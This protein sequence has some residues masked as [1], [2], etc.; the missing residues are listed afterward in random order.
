MPADVEFTHPEWL[1]ALPLV[2]LLLVFAR[3]PW[4]RA[5]AARR[6]MSPSPLRGEIRRLALRLAWLALPLLALA[7]LS[8]TRSQD[9][10]AVVFVVD[11]SASVAPVR[12][13]QLEAVNEALSS[14]R[15]EDIAG[16]VSVG[17]GAR[18]E[19]PLTEGAILDL[20][21]GAPAEAS[22]LASGLILAGGLIP[23]DRTGRV[24]LVSDGR[25]TSG[26][27]EAAARDLSGRGIRVDVI[28]VGPEAVL[29]VRLDQIELP[30]TARERESSVMRLMATAGQPV[31]AQMRVFRDDALI[32]EQPLQ[33]QT[34]RQELALALPPAEPGIHR[35][36]A[37]VSPSDLASDGTPLNN[38]LGAVQR[39]LGQPG[40]LI[41]TSQPGRAGFLPAALTAGAARVNVARPQALPSDLAGLAGYEAVVLADVPASALPAGGMELIERFVRELGRALVM[42]GGPDS[43][44]PGGYADTPI[45]Q[46]LPVYMDLRG[47]G[48]EPRVAMA[49]VIDK[50]GSMEGI[51]M[52]MAK[53]AAVR[54]LRLLKPRDQAAVLAFDSSP[55]WVAPLAEVGDA[56][57]LE[58]AVG[59]V[60][61]GG[62]T[63]IY[64]AVATAFEALRGAE[65]DVRHLIVLTDGHSGSGGDYASLLDQM[66][67][68][69]MTLSSIA[70][71][72]DAD[73]ALLEGLARGGR[74]RAHVATDP[75][76]L[77]EI[78]NK[79]T[80]MATRTILV[81]D[82]FFPAAASSGPLLT[83]LGR[84]PALDGYVAVT[85]KER[86]EVVLVAPEGDPVLAAWQYG[87]G[88]SIAW[89]P[90]LGGRWSSAWSASSTATSLWG[91]AL[92]WLLP[93][94]E[95]GELLARV[96]PEGGGFA[97]LVEN[98]TAWEEVRP[99]RAT[100]TGSGEQHMDLDL[101]PAGPGRYRA[102]LP[103]LDAGAY[104]VQVE[105]ALASGEA[106]RAEAGWSAPYPAEYRTAGVD[107]ATLIRVTEAGGGSI[108][109]DAAAAVRPPEQPAISRWSVAPLLLVLAAVAWPLEIA[110]RRL[111]SMS[112]PG[113]V[114]RLMRG[115]NRARAIAR[116][117]AMSPP[118]AVQQ[119]TTER[120]LERTRTL[121]QHRRKKPLEF[122]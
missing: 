23:S 27:A 117:P 25:E 42:T 2:A 64:P 74:G 109:R 116:R 94:P 93:P 4:W 86:A 91:N 55:Q 105:Q 78:F 14:L 99:T 98:R 106:L 7:G 20:L 18:V 118:A 54:S 107:S 101:S 17:D 44:G 71:G 35:L 77:P 120:L 29:D 1:F 104:I 95:Q 121:R 79:E 70:V 88:R 112:V 113:R 72:T 46:A 41:V 97:L 6:A 3:L 56:A 31:S 110:S 103:R 22:D 108:L 39:V 111:P 45:E 115:R 73:T 80:V 65:A 48:R 57:S 5:A 32:L 75:T 92:S 9:R 84:V 36:R 24:V 15:D 34:G 89:T 51:K 90:D 11:T 8:L 53:E 63:E 38:A 26:D 47:R 96:E 16:V 10:L 68:A 33:L 85:A 69:S 82:T 62:G 52:E 66:R 50:S 67:D 119:A 114:Q 102:P 19:Q 37:E 30:E 100:L 59:S 49:L 81:D 28:A 40:V 122:R 76:R 43:F 13:H 83:G 60:Y 61:A 12:D 21:P 58:S 87:A